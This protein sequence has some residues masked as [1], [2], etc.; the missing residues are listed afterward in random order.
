MLLQAI[1]GGALTF[2]ALFQIAIHAQTTALL[3]RI[4]MSFLPFVVPLSGLLTIIIT[5]VYLWLAVKANAA[6]AAETS[7]I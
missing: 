1:G 7:A 6:A 2:G 5:S 3:A 4:V